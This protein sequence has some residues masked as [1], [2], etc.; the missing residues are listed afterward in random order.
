MTTHTGWVRLS[1]SLPPTDLKVAV[2]DTKLGVL[3]TGRLV[4]YT[5]GKS[6]WRDCRSTFILGDAHWTTPPAGSRT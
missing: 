3:L 2:Y 5:D 4:S 1:D 6:T